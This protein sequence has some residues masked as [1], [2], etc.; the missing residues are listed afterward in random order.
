VGGGVEATAGAEADQNDNGEG[1]QALRQLD[2]IVVGVKDDKRWGPPRSEPAEQLC[3]LFHGNRSGMLS[4]MHALD[5]ERGGPAVRSRGALGQ[6]LVRP[7]GDDRLPSGVARRMVGVT[8][9]GT[10]CRITGPDAQVDGGDRMRI[11]C[12]VP[13]QHGPQGRHVEATLGQGVVEAPP[14][15]AMRGEQA[16]VRQRGDRLRRQQRIGQLEQGIGTAM[17][18]V[19][20]GGAE[21]AEQLQ[22]VG[23]QALQLARMSGTWPTRP[24]FAPPRVKSQA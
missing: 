21:G 22:I 4:G 17:E 8:A 20:Q 1:V 19:M 7:P 2:R 23:E 16:H 14:P 13:R 18:A 24:P 12:S 15:T 10:G 5:V 11:R 6:P 3:D 9:L